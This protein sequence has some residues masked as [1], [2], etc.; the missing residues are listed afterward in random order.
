[1]EYFNGKLRKS[2]DDS[3]IMSGTR[4]EYVIDTSR[5]VGEARGG[6]TPTTNRGSASLS[7][8]FLALKGIAFQGPMCKL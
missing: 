3:F 7:K 1:M 2:D 8:D 6:C 5:A 4:I